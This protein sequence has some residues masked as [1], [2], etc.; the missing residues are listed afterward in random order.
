[1]NDEEIKIRILEILENIDRVI[2]AD[3]I[4][5]QLER[6]VDPGRTQE[7]IRRL[8]RELVIEEHYLIGSTSSGFFK[9]KTRDD[10]KRAT[11]Y[12]LNRIP[13]LKNRAE[14]IANQWNAQN[15]DELIELNNG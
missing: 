3:E 8:I 1:M 13:D 7:E 14:R 10:A 6:A 5:E 12:L 15:P 9:I 2:T 4:Y 11:D